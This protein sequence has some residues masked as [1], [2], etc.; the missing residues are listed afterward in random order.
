ME[1]NYP[2]DYLSTEELAEFQ[3]QRMEAHVAAVAKTS[4]F[5]RRLF[6]Q[7]G[8]EPRTFASWDDFRKLPTTSKEDLSKNNRDFFAVPANKTVEFVTTSGTTSTPITVALTRADISR[9]ATN[10]ARALEIAGLNNSDV[11][12]ITTTLDQRFVAGLAYYLGL[13]KL[14]A[15]SIRIGHGHPQIHADNIKLFAPTALIA[16][17]SFLH[18]LGKYLHDQG[19]AHNIKKVICIGEPLRNADFTDNELT[20]NVKKYWD[21]DLFSTYA[22]TEMATAFTECAA[23]Q[24]GHLL[25]E[26]VYVEILDDAGNPVEPGELGEVVVTPFGIE[27]TPLLRYRT[28]DL[29]RLHTAKCACGRT[30]PRLGPIEGRKAHQLKVKGTTIFPQQIESIL[31]QEHIELFVIELRLNE[32]LLDE[33]TLV[34]PQEM[35]EAS[36]VALTHKMKAKLRVTP[37]YTFLPKAEIKAK[38][39]PVG[40]RKPKKL[41]DLRHA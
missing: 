38:L 27:G 10:E 5:Y 23:Q 2:Q 11:V 26:L 32:N 37:K 3:W 17:P 35:A 6:L 40:S 41:Y 12:Q 13:Q 15:A 19:V 7:Q 31:Q 25:P 29:A 21:A 20:R 22:S 36:T 18:K 9:L 39:F 30:T 34:L 1:K 28:G 4:P 33:V 16:V 24:G 14:E 8:I